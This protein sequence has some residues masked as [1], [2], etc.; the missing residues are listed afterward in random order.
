MP[1]PPSASH[2]CGVLCV[3][4]ATPWLF[5]FIMELHD[6][7]D[8]SLSR[9]SRTTIHTETSWSVRGRGNGH[10]KGDLQRAKDIRIF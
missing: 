3:S 5:Q 8:Y 1:N 9:R 7:H 10:G 4:L 6:S 2:S